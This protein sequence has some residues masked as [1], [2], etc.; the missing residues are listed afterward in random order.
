MR[1]LKSK[2]GG[3]G[4]LRQTL[5][6]YFNKPEK[7]ENEECIEE[8]MGRLKADVLVR[9]LLSHYRWVTTEASLEY[10][11]DSYETHRRENR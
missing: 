2:V 1:L 5:P 6:W 11:R 8:R 9:V 7:K 4:V 3:L 10:N